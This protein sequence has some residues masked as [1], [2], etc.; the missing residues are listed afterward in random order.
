MAR[1]PTDFS[2]QLQELPTRNYI[3][4]LRERA[5]DLT[6]RLPPAYYDQYPGKKQP[7]IYSKRF[8]PIPLTT[9]RRVGST[10]FEGEAALASNSAFLT[11]I[12]SNILTGRVGTFQMECHNAFAYFSWTYQT[13]PVFAFGGAPIN[14]K[15]GSDIFDPVF[16][17][18]GGAQAL[19]NYSGLAFT[20]E[21]PNISFDLELH[22]VKRGV[23][24][25]DGKIPIEA[26]AGVT[27]GPKEMKV[28]LLFP[29]D[30]EIEPRIYINEFRMGNILDTD[31]FF[32]AAS[33]VGWINLVFEGSEV[34]EDHLAEDLLEFVPVET[35]S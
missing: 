32:D 28:P 27:F 34:A 21:Q 9:A 11:P 18:N 20:D 4:I 7:R 30:T 15:A 2:E 3:K 35:P 25:T 16:E 10:G 17:A 22:D 33:V 31:A 8:G 5:Q 23:S 12:G 14:P 13:D 6:D 24:L 19:L 1:I 26:F 29:V